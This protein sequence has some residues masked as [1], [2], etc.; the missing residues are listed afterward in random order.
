M[1]R[2]PSSTEKRQNNELGLALNWRRLF[3]TS[4]I[5]TCP[6]V[7]VLRA[8]QAVHRLT[9]G[10]NEIIKQVNILLYVIHPSGMITLSG[11]REDICNKPLTLI[12]SGSVTG[13]TGT[14]ARHHGTWS[15]VAEVFDH[16]GINEVIN[17]LC[18]CSYVM[19]MKHSP[20]CLET[21]R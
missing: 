8:F 2:F 21:L 19:L 14:C 15:N 18:C 20:L 16:L 10:D 4:F 7:E 13:I 17:V 3:P 11:S 1:V 9:F 6:T 5:K 12:E